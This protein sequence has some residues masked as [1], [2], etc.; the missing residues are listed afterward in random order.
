[1]KHT[2]GPWKA[3][4]EK[5][6]QIEIIGPFPENYPV[7][8]ICVDNDTD[9]ANARLIAAAPDLLEACYVAL[10]GLM[11]YTEAGETNP[12]VLKVCAAIEKAEGKHSQPG[13]VEWL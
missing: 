9:R 8:A 10:E 7:A 11:P 12:L 1:M 2:P 6:G 13:E 4:K 5:L 3:Y